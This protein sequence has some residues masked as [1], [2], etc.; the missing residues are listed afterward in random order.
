M[1]KNAQQEAVQN[2]SIGKKAANEAQ[3]Q[4][5]LE[6]VQQLRSV[7]SVFIQ[8]DFIGVPYSR[9][10]STSRVYLPG[11]D[12]HIPY[13]RFRG[14]WLMKRGFAANGHFRMIALKDLL[15]ICPDKTPEPEAS[16]AAC[17]VIPIGNKLAG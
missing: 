16:E 3:F 13:I 6:A 8:H 9:R 4:T 10:F 1:L 17:R 2:I 15:I 5:M 7:L 11:R 12:T 14:K